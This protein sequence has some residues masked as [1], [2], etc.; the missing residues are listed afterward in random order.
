MANVRAFRSGNWSDVTAT[1]PWWNGTAIFAPVEADVVYTSNFTI[2]ADTTAT[3]NTL[4]NGSAS[5]RVWKDGGTASVA[6]GGIV[7]IATGIV[8]TANGGGFQSANGTLLTLSGTA[9]AEIVGTLGAH[10]TGAGV[11]VLHSGSG[12]LTYTGSATPGWGPG[13]YCINLTGSGSAVLNGTFAGAQGGATNTE[14]VRNSSAA[15]SITINGSVTG[16]VGWGVNNASTGTITVNGSITAGASQAG[17][18]NVSTGTFIVTGGGNI[19]AVNGVPGF[20]SSN[21]NAS[22]RLSCSFISSPNGTAAVYAI[23]YVA[24]AN[25]S[26]APTNAKSRYALNGTST[27]VD[28]FTSDN[29]P[30]GGVATTDVRL[31][32]SYGGGLVGTCAV[33]PASSVGYGVAVGQTTGNAVLNAIDVA[34]FVWAAAS[35]TITGGTVT[36][37]TNSP[38]VPS[39]AS[40]ASQVRTELTSE[41]AKVSALNTDRLAQCATTSIVGSLIAQSNS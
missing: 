19:T 17:A 24:S 20:T 16:A 27:Y 40:I 28:F 7:V 2:T 35:R 10:N 9:S 31:G 32:V 34:T 25:L 26:T 21:V 14:A 12:V 33:P 13:T 37:L 5:S 3:V 30:N 18:N 41:L 39:P 23:K 22:N 6:A 38:N 4:T 29:N 36:T 15:A 8:L 1:S 11:G